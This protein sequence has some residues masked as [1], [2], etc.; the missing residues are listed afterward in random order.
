M[1]GKDVSLLLLAG[2]Q[3]GSP[4]HVRERPGRS[5]EIIDQWRITPACAGKTNSKAAKVAEQ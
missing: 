1:C 3:P 4:P 2:C 5:K